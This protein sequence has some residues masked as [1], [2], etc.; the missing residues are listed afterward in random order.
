L[1]CVSSV[2]LIPPPE[3]EVDARDNAN[4]QNQQQQASYNN[5]SMH[6]LFVSYRRRNID[7]TSTDNKTNNSSERNNTAT[8]SSSTPT[9]GVCCYELGGLRIPGAHLNTNSNLQSTS[10]VS[11]RY[12]MDG[13]DVPSSNLCSILSPPSLVFNNQDVKSTPQYTVARSDGLHFYSRS[14]KAGVCPVDGD[15]IA[16]CHLPPVSPVAYLKRRRPRRVL[17]NNEEQKNVGGGDE[18]VMMPSGGGG[19]NDSTVAGASYVLV[20][21]TDAKAHRDAVDIYDTSNKLVG[22]HVLLSPGHRA[23]RTV[24]LMASP[25]VR[26]GVLV[27]GGRASAVVFTSGGSI[28]TLTEKVTPD[29][30]ALLVQKQL[31][32][33]AISMAFSDPA[34]YSPDD[35]TG[36]Y[37]K[38]AEYL[39]RK[40]E[41]SAAM[42]QYI[43]TIGS[44]ESSHVIFRYLDAP[45]IPLVVKYLEAL[46]AKG[47]ASSV[48]DEMLRT[49]YLKLGDHESARGILSPSAAGDGGMSALPL[50]P[51]GSEIPT[52]SIS[53]N[54][55]ACAD[56]PSEM[57]AAMLPR[58]TGGGRGARGARSPVGKITCS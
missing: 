42:D 8:T 38:Y 21:T 40:G 2:E 44:L 43:L 52:V 34:F 10:V 18:N 6:R 31:Y 39:Y 30:V 57:L 22:F 4:Q 20:A 27:R 7:P 37:R 5:G 25:V 41:F 3:S 56:D 46:Q 28:V 35:I 15:K 1:Y 54:L 50:N 51:D 19:R 45:K 17:D 55:L 29:Q 32:P 11:A 26:N 33:A 12:D 23:L 9:G 49:C 16:L 13:R 47:L 24:G 14:E 53:R 36:L 48:H 58:S